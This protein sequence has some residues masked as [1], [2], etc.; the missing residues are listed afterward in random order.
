MYSFCVCFP[1]TI[2]EGLD[3][4]NLDNE[5][6]TLAT[7]RFLER[8]R[9]KFKKSCRHWLVTELGQTNTER[10][11]LHGL[12]FTTEG[13]ETIE[14]IWKY[15]HVYIGDYVNEKTIN[16]IVKYISKTDQLH[17]EYKSK[18]L[19]SPGIGKGY[20]DRLDAKNNRYKQDTNETYKT[21]NGIKLNLPIYLFLYHLPIVPL[22]PVFLAIVLLFLLPCIFDFCNILVGLV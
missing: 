7:R 8:W 3:G 16:Y 17:K 21:R 9:K 13:I 15:G 2:I 20:V 1:V 4:Y 22:C 14:E 18:V 12:L 11:H 5:I 6:A 19:T 10:I